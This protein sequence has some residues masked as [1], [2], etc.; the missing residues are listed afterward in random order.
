MDL[1]KSP[2]V[3]TTD[4]ED[5]SS[6]GE[7]ERGVSGRSVEL[8]Q[9]LHEEHAT[10]L[11]VTGQQNEIHEQSCSIPNQNGPSYIISKHPQRNADF[12]RT[13]QILPKGPS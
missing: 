10:G 4:A 3:L 7:E 1:V 9:Q 2:E 12:K 8:L 6:N 11:Q 13:T 5:A